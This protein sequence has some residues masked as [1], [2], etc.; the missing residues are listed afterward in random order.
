MSFPLFPP[1]PACLQLIA[2]ENH[3]VQW[4]TPLGLPVVQPYR[5]AKR[6]IVCTAIQMLVVSEPDID[7]KVRGH[8]WEGEG[9]MA[10]GV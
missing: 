7:G 2:L 9:G 1:H 3:A 4:T 8:R 6:Q 10:H 5:K